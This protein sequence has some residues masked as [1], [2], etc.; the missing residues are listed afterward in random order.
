M[1]G[2]E[3]LEPS[4][5]GVKVLCLTAWLHPNIF[6]TFIMYALPIEL[7]ARFSGWHYRTRTDDITFK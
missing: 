4:S 7:K 6:K 2:V 5:A 1:A 3:G